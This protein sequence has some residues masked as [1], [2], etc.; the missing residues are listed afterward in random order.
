MAALYEEARQLSK[1]ADKAFIKISDDDI[2]ELASAFRKFGFWRSDLTTGHVYMSTE[3]CEIYGLEPSTTTPINVADVARAFHP[4]DRDR[5]FSAIEETVA[6]GRGGHFVYRVRCGG[7]HYRPV[8]MVMAI[9]EREGG[10]GEIIGIVYELFPKTTTAGRMDPEF[11]DLAVGIGAENPESHSLRREDGSVV[12]LTMAEAAD[13]VTAYRPY[14]FFRQEY[15][16][17]RCFFSDQA[18]DIYGMQFNQEPA[19]IPEMVRR[20]HSEDIPVVTRTFEEVARL[21]QGFHLIHRYKNAEGGYKYVR[22]VAK[23]RE[24]D[25]PGGEMVGVVYEFYDHLRLT[26][27]V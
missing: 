2:V 15:E 6:S 18:G 23:P 10:S 20:T 26:E 4:A 16:T 3:A 13:L 19:N 8:R 24:S 21:K 9:R 17:G 1:E 14:G 22:L 12:G 27:I 5:A 7:D 11:G 25:L